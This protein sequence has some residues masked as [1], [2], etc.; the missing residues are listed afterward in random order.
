MDTF[1]PYSIPPPQ[2]QPSPPNPRRKLYLWLGIGGGIVVFCGVAAVVAVF[3]SLLV[4]SMR[5]PAAALGTYT[6]ELIRKDY[7]AAYASASPGFRAGATLPA[8]VEYHGKLNDEL[9]ALKSVHQTHW[10][11]ETKNGITSSTIEATL[12][13]ERGS[14]AFEFVLRKE[15]GVWRVYSYKPH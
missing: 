11:I 10:S 6:D 8:L 4:T 15:G 9:G 1:A 13:F 2:P 12:D 5:Q 14:R 7:Q 3:V